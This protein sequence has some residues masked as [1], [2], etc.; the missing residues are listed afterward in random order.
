MSLDAVQRVCT[1]IFSYDVF[2]VLS[3]LQE[4]DDERIKA[5]STFEIPTIMYFFSLIFNPCPSRLCGKEPISVPFAPGFLPAVRGLCFLQPDPKHHQDC[6]VMEQGQLL[7]VRVD[8]S[9][10][11]S[12]SSV[13]FEET[14]S[15]TQTVLLYVRDG[16]LSDTC[17]CGQVGTYT[18]MRAQAHTLACT[19]GNFT[20]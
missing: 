6:V 5:L 13:C 4:G 15:C 12:A 3:K 14:T 8:C 9:I 7:P 11:G 17:T 1:K 20:C 16:G 10:T 2:S 19:Q 18:H